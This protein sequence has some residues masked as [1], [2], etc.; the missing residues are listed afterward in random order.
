MLC[1]DKKMEIQ[2]LNHHD[3]NF[4]A[5]LQPE[6]WDSILPKMVFYVESSFCF[7]IKVIID[8]KIVGLG[9][10]IIHENTAWLGHIIV[11]NENRGKGLGK[12]ITQKLIEIAKQKQCQTILLIA[13]EFG[14][15]VYEKVGFVTQT[16]YLFFKDISLEKLPNVS[17]VSFT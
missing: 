1:V 4:I 8:N 12:L 11:H 14:A 9:A 7:P 16:E 3:I 15:P 2:V 13:T 10:T 17:F 5:E 6:G